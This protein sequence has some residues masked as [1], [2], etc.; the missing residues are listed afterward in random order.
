MS[1][2]KVIVGENSAGKSKVADPHPATEE[3]YDRIP[4][5]GGANPPKAPDTGP[6]SYAHD[7]GPPPRPH[8]KGAGSA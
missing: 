8:N 7:G 2:N 5:P 6:N 3:H 4:H 1:R